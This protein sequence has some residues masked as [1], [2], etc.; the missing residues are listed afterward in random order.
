MIKQSQR[1]MEAGS[2]IREELALIRRRQEM[3]RD[4][5]K[6]KIRKL[7]EFWK[8]EPYPDT[9]ERLTSVRRILETKR[10][11][12]ARWKREGLCRKCGSRFRDLDPCPGVKIT[13]LCER[14]QVGEIIYRKRRQRLL[15]RARELSKYIKDLVC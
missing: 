4:N 1:R 9:H 2:G 11:K 13:D 6:Q 3:K 15:E 14:C 12:R 8:I 5:R 10:D 7:R